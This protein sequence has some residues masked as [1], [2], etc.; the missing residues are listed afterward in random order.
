MTY[1]V[2]KFHHVI[3]G[4]STAQLATNTSLGDDKNEPTK[5][6]FAVF[7]TRLPNQPSKP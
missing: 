7:K 2:T 5:F 1:V 4:I 3:E 6:Y